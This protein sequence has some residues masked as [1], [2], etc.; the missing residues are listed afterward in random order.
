MRIKLASE[1]EL[2]QRLGV[3][4]VSVDAPEFLRYAHEERIKWVDTDGAS[5]ATSDRVLEIGRRAF[6]DFGITFAP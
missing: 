5:T 1:L 4:P 6:A 3:R 2:A